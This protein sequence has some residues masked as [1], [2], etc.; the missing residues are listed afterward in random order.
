MQKADL[1]S[2]ALIAAAAAGCYASS[3]HNGFVFDDSAYLTSPVVLRFGLADAF[4]QNWLQLDM[5][6]LEGQVL[7]LPTRD[8][9]MIPVEEQLIVEVCSK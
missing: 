1:G 5:A 7:A 2:V 9:V 4:L 6:K 8:D 3:L